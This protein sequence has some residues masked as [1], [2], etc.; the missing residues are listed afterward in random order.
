MT[1][2]APNIMGYTVGESILPVGLT[3]INRETADE[4]I[5]Y[6]SKTGHIYQ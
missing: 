4:I 1:K 6:H 5:Q 2:W 3:L